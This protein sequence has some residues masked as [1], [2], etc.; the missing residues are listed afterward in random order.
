MKQQNRMK[1]TKEIKESNLTESEYL[2]HTKFGIA[3]CTKKGEQPRQSPEN[4]RFADAPAVVEDT[5]GGDENSST[6]DDTDND[7]NRLDDAD[8]LLHLDPVGAVGFG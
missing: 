2:K 5:P 8:L 7:G 6:N 4:E 3:K 1:W